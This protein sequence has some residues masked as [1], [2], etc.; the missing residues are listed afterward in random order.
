MAKVIKLGQYKNIEVE[1]E[2]KQVTD[3]MV[4]QQVNAIVAQNPMLVD[5]EGLVENGDI[6]IIDFEGFKEGVPFDGGKAE[7]YQLEI[8]SGSFIPGFEEQMVGMA[9]GETRELNLTF[10]ENYGAAELAGA[11]VVFKVTVHQIKNKQVSELSDEY[12]ASFGNPN[13]KTVEDLKQMVRFQLE[14]QFRQERARMVEDK[15][16]DVLLSASEV[17]FDEEAGLGPDDFPLGF[18]VTVS[19]EHGMPRDRD[20]IESMFNKGSGRI[21][22]VPSE[23]VSSGDK[24][25]T[26]DEETGKNNP[27]P[28]KT[29]NTYVTTK[30]SS[31]NIIID[32]NK[33]N[34]SPKYIKIDR[35]LKNDNIYTVGFKDESKLSSRIP[36][37]AAVEWI[38]K[39]GFN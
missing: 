24:E 3:E 31:Q 19:L 4:E 26:V 12:V 1:V 32:I 10:P 38:T 9:K 23:F 17:E 27:N 22:V 36:Y 15:V 7:G 13:L 30:T 25:T 29:A 20:G 39:K 5:K 16:L 37:H 28:E 2:S 35:K 34:S 11:A 21:Y 8:G 6:T 33:N 18:T 14:D